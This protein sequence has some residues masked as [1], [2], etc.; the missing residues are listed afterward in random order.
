MSTIHVQKYLNKKLKTKHLSLPPVRLLL[1]IKNRCDTS[2]ILASDDCDIVE[3]N[4]ER[5]QTHQW[6]DKIVQLP[7]IAGNSNATIVVV[8]WSYAVQPVQALTNRCPRCSI[9]A[10]KL[11]LSELKH[12]LGNFTRNFPDPVSFRL[13]HALFYEHFHCPCFSYVKSMWPDYWNLELA[14]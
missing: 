5:L 4:V 13:V 8:W 3:I 14:H 7:N 10:N 6:D 2:I 12:W 11:H 1:F 9:D